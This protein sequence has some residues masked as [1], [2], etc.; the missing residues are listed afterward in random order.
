[1]HHVRIS[2]VFDLHCMNLIVLGV[3]FQGLQPVLSVKNGDMNMN[4]MMDSDED[5]ERLERI[6]ADHVLAGLRDTV[7]APF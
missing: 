2:W 7:T 6:P 1:M 3:E 5:G 4:M